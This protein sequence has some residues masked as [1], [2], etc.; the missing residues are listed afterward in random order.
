MLHVGI[1]V[2]FETE[3]VT[4]AFCATAPWLVMLHTT[5]ACDKVTK[6]K[7]TE[8]SNNE[9]R[10]LLVIFTNL[11]RMRGSFPPPHFRSRMHLLSFQF[12][13]YEPNIKHKQLKKVPAIRGW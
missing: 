5:D 11:A 1:S 12:V 2:A 13:S 6:T 3:S 8:I 4:F 10:G 7:T 9:Y